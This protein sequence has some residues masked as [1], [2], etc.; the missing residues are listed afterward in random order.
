LLITSN[1]KASIKF[2]KKIIWNYR[3]ISICSSTAN[4]ISYIMAVIS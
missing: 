3:A 4:S 2:G 1:S